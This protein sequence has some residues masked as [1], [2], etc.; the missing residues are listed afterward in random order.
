MQ[1]IDGKKIAVDIIARLK[2]F[3]RPDK[4]LA[5]IYVGKN[6]SS[7]SFLRQKEKIA[8]ELGVDFRIN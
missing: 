1:I 3:P 6:K 2:K 5:A 7:E 8:K 4:I